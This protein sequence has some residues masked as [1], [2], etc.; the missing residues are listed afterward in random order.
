MLRPQP[1]IGTWSLPA[2]CRS[3]SIGRTRPKRFGSDEPWR[4]R[5]RSVRFRTRPSRVRIAAAAFDLSCPA[6]DA[7]SQRRSHDPSRNPRLREG[8]ESRCGSKAAG[9]I[10]RSC[11]WSTCRGGHVE[12]PAV[13][14][15]IVSHA[16]VPDGARINSPIRQDSRDRRLGGSSRRGDCGA[17]PALRGNH[18]S[19]GLRE[20][21]SPACGSPRICH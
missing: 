1:E 6:N 21:T 13:P 9:A 18:H 7:H 11:E 17:E 10:G 5:R 3:A 16:V 14:S 4:V 12:P 19:G 15:S 8:W 20:C 2:A